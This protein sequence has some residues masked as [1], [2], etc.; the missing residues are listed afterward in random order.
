[1]VILSKS[2]MIFHLFRCFR[3]RFKPKRAYSCG[4]M[5]IFRG[6][7]TTKCQ[8]DIVQMK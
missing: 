5:V 8:V 6:I 3:L 7:N 4:K 1:M 2:V